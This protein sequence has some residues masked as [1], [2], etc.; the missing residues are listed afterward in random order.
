MNVKIVLIEIADKLFAEN[1]DLYKQRQMIVEHPFGTI[2][3]ALGYTYFLTRGHENVKNKSYLHCFTYNLKR[4]IN[5]I[6]VALL[7]DAIKAKM[8]K[9]NKI[10]FIQNRHFFNFVSFYEKSLKL[11]VAT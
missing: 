3:R 11:K 8:A 6:G 10:N 4:V 1:L 2:K 9:L 7:V 5:I